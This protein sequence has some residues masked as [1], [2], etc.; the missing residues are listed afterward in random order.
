MDNDKKEN[1]LQYIEDLEKEELKQSINLESNVQQT[2]DEEF[3]EIIIDH[4]LIPLSECN[5]LIHKSEGPYV[6]LT[7]TLYRTIAY[8]KFKNLMM[9]KLKSGQCVEIDKYSSLFC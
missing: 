6:P 5:K 4:I 9:K 2:D 8:R 7:M 1:I 3:E